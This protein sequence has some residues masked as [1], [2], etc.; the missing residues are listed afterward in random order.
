MNSRFFAVLFMD[1]FLLGSNPDS[2][3]EEKYD[4]FYTT[5]GFYSL[6]SIY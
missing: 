6:N 2:M 1:N 3:A 5:Q 4:L